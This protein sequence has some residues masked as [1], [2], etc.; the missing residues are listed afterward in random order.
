M[1]ADWN[2]Y[3]TLTSTYYKLVVEK[4]AHIRARKMT[5]EIRALLEDTVRWCREKG[6]EPRQWIFCLF[7]ARNWMAA[8]K[9]EKSNLQSV[10]MLRRYKQMSGL[11]FFKVRRRATQRE[12]AEDSW[13]DPNR[14]IDPSIEAEKLHMLRSNNTQ[15]CFSKILDRTLG[16]HPHSKVCAECPLAGP[17][18]LKLQSLVPFN[19]IALR[20][21]KI[22]SREVQAKLKDR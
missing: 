2:Y 11:G 13:F 15:E 9:L 21:G 20:L 8:P 10:N 7:K 19:I 1:L 16:W 22:T 6:V 5:D 4:H 17:C 14:D 12:E 18:S 3:R